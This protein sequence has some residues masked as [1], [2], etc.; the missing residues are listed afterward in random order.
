MPV[1]SSCIKN[2]SEVRVSNLQELVYKQG[3]AGITYKAH[4]RVDAIAPDLN[5]EE[6]RLENEEEDLATKK[7]NVDEIQK[8]IEDRASSIKNAE[9]GADDL[10]TRIDS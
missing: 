9:D 6:S 8:K 10:K 1:T 5:K 2:L 4:D 7:N 3:Q